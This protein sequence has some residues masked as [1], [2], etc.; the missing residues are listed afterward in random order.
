M[1]HRDDL[2][3]QPP[4]TSVQDPLLALGKPGEI[5]GGKLF[6]EPF[7]GVKPLVPLGGRGAQRRAS[8]VG[9]D[10]RLCAARITQERFA[11]GGLL[12][13]PVARQERFGLACRKRMPPDGVGQPDLFALAERAQRQ[14][15]GQGQAAAIQSGLQLRRQAAKESQATL[16]PQLPA[17]QKFSDGRQG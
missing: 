7:R 2:G 10:R 13:H 12:D 3:G 15:N 17:P 16:H 8:L 6:Q 5:G 1:G 11:P 14:R 9:G 4:S